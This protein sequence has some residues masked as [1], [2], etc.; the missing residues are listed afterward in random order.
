MSFLTPDTRVRCGKCHGDGMVPL[1]PQLNRTLDMIVRRPHSNAAEL[2][3]LLKVKPTA[4]CNRVNKLIALGL[5]VN[6]PDNDRAMRIRA[7]RL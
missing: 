5:V 6:E 2:A 4:M 1:P 7:A 3:R